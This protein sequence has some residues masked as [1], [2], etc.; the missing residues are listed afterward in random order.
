MF[1][2][3]ADVSGARAHFVSKK[4]LRPFLFDACNTA[5]RLFRASVTSEKTGSV[6]VGGW[7]A[8]LGAPIIGTNCWI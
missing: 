4:S 3:H 1:H 8:A 6:T 7:S 2:G 5:C